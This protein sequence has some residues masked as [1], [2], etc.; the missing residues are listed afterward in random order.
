MIPRHRCNNGFQVTSEEETARNMTD[1]TISKTLKSFHP[2]RLVR[3]GSTI[4]GRTRPHTFILIYNFFLI[5]FTSQ[6]P[7]SIL[8]IMPQAKLHLYARGSR[9]LD[10]VDPNPDAMIET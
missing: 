4:R 2:E 6:H 9:K 5:R 3:L 8:D 7:R 1:V 10:C